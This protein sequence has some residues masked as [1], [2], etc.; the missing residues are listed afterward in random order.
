MDVTSPGWRGRLPDFA[1]VHILVVE[2]DLD[3]RHLL[4]LLLEHC[5]ARVTAAASVKEAFETIGRDRPD[6]ILSDI[7]MAL[8]DGF[9]LIRRLR[10]LPPEAGGRIPAAAVTAYASGGDRARVLAAGFQEH[11]A[12][13]VEPIELT[14]IVAR[15]VGRH[16]HR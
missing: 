16:P 9:V 12:K 15:L 14:A 5:G 1:D 3:T 13:P 10:A 2:D 7:G 8:E 4:R 6:V 11:V